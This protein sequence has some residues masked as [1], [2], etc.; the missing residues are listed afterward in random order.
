MERACAAS[1]VPRYASYL[2]WSLETLHRLRVYNFFVCHFLKWQRFKLRKEINMLL[3][4]DILYLISILIITIP[5]AEI[6]AREM[7]FV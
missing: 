3:L 5:L 7:M 4:A 2:F 6:R 1:L